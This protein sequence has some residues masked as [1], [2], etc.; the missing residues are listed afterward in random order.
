[1]IGQT[2]VYGLDNRRVGVRGRYTEDRGN[3][4][5]W[6]VDGRPGDF[7]VPVTN[8]GGWG[9]IMDYVLVMG[10]VGIRQDGSDGHDWSWT[11]CPLPVHL[12]SGPVPDTHVTGSVKGSRPDSCH[13]YRKSS[14]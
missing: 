1:M 2:T 8:D 11:P 6:V 14:A 5:E 4:I 3:P 7:T 9:S 10:V 13:R 12:W